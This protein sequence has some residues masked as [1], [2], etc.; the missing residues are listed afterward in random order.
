M[1]QQVIPQMKKQ[2][3][4]HVVNI[5]ALLADQ[6]SGAVP[7]V[8]AVLLKSPMSFDHLAKVMQDFTEQLHL[9]RYTLF[10]Q[11]YGGPVGFRMALG[12]G[13]CS[14]RRAPSRSR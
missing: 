11:D 14:P 3:P 13:A 4:G 2:N 8:L 12:R 7:A 5:S 6:R 9:D 10:M 1:S